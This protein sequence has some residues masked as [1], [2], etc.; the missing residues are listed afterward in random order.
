MIL[1]LVP[2]A[3]NQDEY[4]AGN[5]KAVEANRLALDCAGLPSRLV[6]FDG[7]NLTTVLSQVTSDIRHL[8]IEY[9]WWP[10][11]LMQLKKKHPQIRVHVRTHNAEAYQHLHRATAG[12]RDYANVRLWRKFLQLAWRDSRCRLAA[13]TLLGISDWDN[14]NY[15]QWLPGKALIRYLPYY[16]PWP[17][18][19]PEVEPR[20]WNLRKADILSMGGNF[21]PSGMANVANF[22]TLANKLSRVSGNRWSFLL[23]WWSR[24]HKRV[25]EVSRH[26]EIVRDCREP[27]DLLC[28]V[29]ALAVLT[30]L[31][32]GFKTTI[33]DGLAAGCH[34]IVHPQLARRL[35]LQVKQLCLICDPSR[36]EDIIKL[37]DALSTPPRSH[38]INE[39]LSEMA[40]DIFRSTFKTNQ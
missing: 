32:F 10:D 16:S 27:W 13:D 29:R 20:P 5:W 28:Q 11:F 38:N 12:V 35:P 34:V 23:T 8:L 6:R 4:G 31:G 14:A 19:R 24:W 40:V 15:W 2:S 7:D 30:P 3:I 37:A 36:D 21:D 39:K 18:L 17:S 33:V 9:S 1:H 22:D 26:I 25:P